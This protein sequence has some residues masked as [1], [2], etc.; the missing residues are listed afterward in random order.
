V[1]VVRAF[2][3]V[4]YGCRLLPPT[5]IYIAVAANIVVGN[6]CIVYYY[7]LIQTRVPRFVDTCYILKYKI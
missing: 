6:E 3:F 4:V 2:L 5:S 7:Y 1:P